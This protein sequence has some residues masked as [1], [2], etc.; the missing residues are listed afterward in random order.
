MEQLP[1]NL[2]FRDTMPRVHVRA[3]HQSAAT[4]F[5]AK[6]GKS[7][8][9]ESRKIEGKKL[10]SVEKRRASAW[11]TPWTRQVFLNSSLYLNV[12]VC[13]MYVLMMYMYVFVSIF[14]NFQYVSVCAYPCLSMLLYALI[15]LCIMLYLYVCNCI[16]LYQ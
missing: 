3:H 10:K 6:V 4:R 2:E 15:S 5:R 13:I 16:I 9:T 11:P 1:H 14:F 8:K 12:Y 7:R